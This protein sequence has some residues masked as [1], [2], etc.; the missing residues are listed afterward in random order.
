MM[1]LPPPPPKAVFSLQALLDGVCRRLAV[2]L[3]C[4]VEAG[5]VPLSAGHRAPAFAGQPS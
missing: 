1:L 2:V 4:V 3:C 5:G